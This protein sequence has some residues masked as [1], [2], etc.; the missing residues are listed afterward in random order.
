MSYL[1]DH[2]NDFKL[3]HVLL[4]Q[5]YTITYTEHNSE[6]SKCIDAIIVA[7]STDELNIQVNEKFD[8]LPIIE[9]GGIVCLNIM[10]DELFFMSLAISKP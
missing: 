7:S 4:W 3:K 6:S 9:Q 8:L 2:M 1:L 5:N 10:L